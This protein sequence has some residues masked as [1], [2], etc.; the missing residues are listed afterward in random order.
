VSLLRTSSNKFYRQGVESA[1]ELANGFPDNREDLFRYDAVVVGSLDAVEL[2]TDQQ[3]LLRDFVSVR[4]GSL[5]MLAGRQGLADGSWGRSVT[6]AVL[7]VTLSSRVND[8]TFERGR[9]QVLPTL[10]GYRTPWLALTSESTVVDQWE[11]LPAIADAQDLGEPKPGAITLLSRVSADDPLSP[12]KPL[13]V[14]QRYG[15]GR[16]FVMGTSGTWRW[17]M[18]LPSTDER[19]EKFWQQLMGALVENSLPRMNLVM[20]QSVVRDAAVASVSLTAYNEDYAPVQSSVYPLRLTQPDGIVSTIELTADLAKPGRFTGQ[21]PADLAGAY[22]ITASTPVRG[23][24]PAQAPKTEERWWLSEKGNAEL[25]NSRL[26]EDFLVRI[27]DVTG[28]SYLNLAEVNRLESVLIG[29]NAALKRENRLPL[30]S[31]PFFFLLLIALKLIEWFLR[32]SW[33]RL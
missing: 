9:W 28:G 19:H 32:L 22:A 6:A 14:T 2:T 8:Q 1:N 7:P 21:V 29:N 26:N 18:N 11:T 20:D 5:L 13:L 24:S 12:A 31:M 23:E 16:S 33:K 4:G 15:K 27:A 10:D 17:Q 25:Y 30:W 3:S